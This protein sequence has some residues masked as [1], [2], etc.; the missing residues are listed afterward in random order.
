MNKYVYT[1]NLI[2]TLNVF[3]VGG[4]MTCP[5]FLIHFTDACV[6]WCE[7]IN[8]E[9]RW[10]VDG[11]FLQRASRRELKE[12]AVSDVQDPPLEVKKK[13]EKKNKKIRKTDVADNVNEG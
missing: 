13:G 10:K 6:G 4:H 2:L 3:G 5:Q 1:N 9:K 12:M 8:S 7:H 11:N